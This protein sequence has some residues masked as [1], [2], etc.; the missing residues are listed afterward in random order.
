MLLPRSNLVIALSSLAIFYLQA[1]SYITIVHH[2]LQQ[3]QHTHYRSQQWTVM[4]SLDSDASIYSCESYQG[5]QEPTPKPCMSPHDLDILKEIGAGR[6]SKTYLVRHKESAKLYALK[7]VSKAG[8]SDAEVQRTLKQQAV[9]AVI[10]KTGNFLLPLVASWHDERNFYITTDYI[11]GGDFAAEVGSC[12][13]FKAVRA[14]FCAAQLVLALENLHR[15]NIVHRDITL[16]NILI[17]AMGYI[18]LGGYGVSNI[19]EEPGVGSLTADTSFLDFVVDP[20]CNAGTFL[21]PPAT[22]PTMCGIAGTPH[23]MS[24]QQHQG[25]EYSYDADI[26]GVGVVLYRMLTG[27]LPFGN[28]SSCVEEIGH[29]VMHAPLV[30]PQNKEIDATTIEF[31]SGL[32]AKDVRDRLTMA[33]IKTHK[34]FEEIWHRRPTWCLG[35]PVCLRSRRIPGHLSADGWGDVPVLQDPHPEF[36]SSR[37]ASPSLDL[38]SWTLRLLAPLLLPPLLL[39]LLLLLP[40]PP[41]IYHDDGTTIVARRTLEAQSRCVS[42]S[43]RLSPIA[44][45]SPA[46]SSVGSSPRS[47]LFTAVSRST[48][49]TTASS[50]SPS[51]IPGRE[52][53]DA[54]SGPDHVGLSPA[55]TCA[56]PTPAFCPA[57]VSAG[58]RLRVASRSAAVPSPSQGLG[59]FNFTPAPLSSG[60]V[61]RDTRHKR[62]AALIPEPTP[63]TTK[64]RCPKAPRAP[65]VRAPRIKR[66]APPATTPVTGEPGQ[67]ESEAAGQAPRPIVLG[68]ELPHENVIT[69]MRAHIWRLQDEAWGIPAIEVDR[70]CL[71]SA[72]SADTIPNLVAEAQ[73]DQEDIGRESLGRAIWGWAASMWTARRSTRTAAA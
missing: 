1:Q 10:A 65:L 66:T 64:I 33:Q 9:H 25:I 18:T 71:G 42:S 27:K 12:G 35:G 20:S 38:L 51:P 21:R 40:P 46:P 62:S 39:L 11:R 52:F 50:L 3:H 70:I 54:L 73:E 60:P 4:S 43:E 32:L 69:R 68:V 15:L 37:I 14:R 31:L 53:S 6:I 17:D 72:W 22:A 49:P 57:T 34:Y 55:S 48:T 16:N 47:S 63:S 59:I 24:P 30:F 5:P 56:P 23:A 67:L 36:N 45:S 61:L 13:T 41:K 44:A 8:L 7:V 29:D 58:L 2:A 19:F 26:W 28:D